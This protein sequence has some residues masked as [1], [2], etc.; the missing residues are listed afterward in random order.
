MTG[1]S[2]SA[3]YNGIPLGG[4]GGSGVVFAL[5][6][7]ASVAVEFSTDEGWS[8]R[9]S[10]RD[11]VASG[12][13]RSTYADALAAG[14]AAVQKALDVFSVRGKADLLT[15]DTENHHIVGWEDSGTNVLRLVATNVVHADFGTPSLTVT[16]AAGDMQPSPPEV[17]TWHQSMRFYRQ[18]QLAD[19]LFD[20]LRSLWLAAENLLDALRPQTAGEGEGQWLRAALKAAEAHVDLVR[21]LP[22]GSHKAPHNHAYEY[23]YDQLRVSIFHAKGSRSPRLPHEVDAM[24]DLA[25]RHERLTRFYIDLLGE[26]TGVRRPTGVM[27]YAGF[28]LMTAGWDNDPQVHITDDSA[29]FSEEDTVPNPAG[30][31]V[32]TATS[33]RDH[34]LERPG[35]KT[36]LARVSTSKLQKVEAIRKVVLSLGG[37]LVACATVDGELLLGGV[38]RFEMQNGLR[39]KNM[40]TPRSFT[41]I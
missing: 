24:A 2:R 10:G 17:E 22:D 18:A 31:R 12:P 11:I 38:D 6:G 21:Y 34:E 9:V 29:P 15:V 20:S 7:A 30:G 13:S 33:V 26:V 37:A 41:G 36:L 1:S 14:L 35:L 16:N 28:D 4:S 27:T 3:T 23:F 39:L 40:G 8:V 19:D 25:Q 5:A 32:V